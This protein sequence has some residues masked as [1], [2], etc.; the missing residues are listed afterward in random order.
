MIEPGK[1][2]C[3]KSQ[4]TSA[5]QP[6]AKRSSCL[7]KVI[8]IERILIATPTNA[9]QIKLVHSRLSSSP[10]L[11]ISWSQL[12]IL[13]ECLVIIPK[14]MTVERIKAGKPSEQRPVE[15]TNPQISPASFCTYRGS[16]SMRASFERWQI[17]RDSLRR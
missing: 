17:L 16:S 15:T 14:L 10:R 1:R 6:S 12:Y 8:K 4:R 13:H 11:S 9:L 5:R 7:F 2:I 3:A